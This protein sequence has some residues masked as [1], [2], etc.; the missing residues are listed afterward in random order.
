MDRL[1]SASDLASFRLAVR[2]KR[3]PSV[4]EIS[5]CGGTGCRAWGA[6]QVVSRFETELKVQGQEKRVLLKRVGCAG[7]CERGPLVTIRPQGIFYQ[8][9]APEDVAEVVAETIGKGNILGRL[10]FAEATSGRRYVYESEVPFYAMQKRTVLSLN[11]VVDPTSIQDYISH[12]GYGSLE[13]VLSWDPGRVIDTVERAGLRGRGGGGFPTGTKWRFAREAVGSQKFIVCN[14]DEGD[15]GAYMDRSILEGNPHSVIDGM[16]VGA[17]AIGAGHGYIYCRAEYPLAI[18]R[19]GIAID[20]VR[21]LGILGD[22]ILGSGFSFDI[23]LC[24]GAGAF[25]W[26]RNR[27]DCVHRGPAGHASPQAAIP[28]PERPF[29]VSHRHQ[30][31]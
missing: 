23:R 11:G 8:R 3:D 2:R 29:R 27:F 13:E 22:N 9:V 31:R 16:I 17:Y 21:E 30:Q 12:G 15:P 10:L 20:Q 18:E 5:V 28:S 25:V 19:L 6:E 24:Q 4:V 26:G 1:K 7:F 14:A